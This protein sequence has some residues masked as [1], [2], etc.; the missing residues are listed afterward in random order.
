[1]DD[2]ELEYDRTYGAG[3]GP[4]GNPDSAGPSSFEHGHHAPD[5]GLDIDELMAPVGFQG[6]NNGVASA[7]ETPV[8]QLIRLWMNERHAPDILPVQEHLLAGILDHIRRQSEAIQLLRSDPSSSEEEHFRITLV[9]TE[10]E[11]IKFIVRSYLRTRLFKIEKY[12]RYITSDPDIQTRISASERAYAS[13]Q[14]QILDQHFWVTVLQSLPE[15]QAHLDDTP[16]FT[17]SMITKPDKS[18]AVFVHALQPCP[19]VQLPDGSTLEMDKGHISLLPF[20]VVEHLVLRGEVEL[21]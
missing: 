20:Y 6:G 17:P 21:V 9:Q 12:A 8:Q 3:S 14:A 15:S 1:M 19:P 5:D 18:R 7:E 10:V 11:R 4:T 16:L 13:K 2:W